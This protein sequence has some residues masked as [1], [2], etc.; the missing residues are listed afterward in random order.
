MSR[1]YEGSD[2]GTLYQQE[3]RLREEY[4]RVKYGDEREQ[5]N[6]EIERELEKIK[7]EWSRRSD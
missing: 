1:E 5:R 6:S 4:N 2:S 3:R 7:H